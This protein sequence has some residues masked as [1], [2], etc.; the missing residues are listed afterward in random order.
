MN[1]ERLV[2]L[3]TDFQEGSPYIAQ[4]K[5]VLYSYAQNVKIVDGT[6]SIPPQN[7]E[8]AAYT[9]AQIVPFFPPETIHIVVVDPG[10][11]SSRRLVA[12]PYGEQFILCP[13]NGILTLLSE[14]MAIQKSYEIQNRTYFLRE[15]SATF[16]GRDIL[17]P[18]AAWLA[19]GGSP[20]D[21]GPAV[22]PESLVRLNIVH[23]KRSDFG[24]E[25][26]IVF[27]D[28][29]GNLITNIEQADWPIPEGKCFRLNGKL[30]VQMV[31][32][33]A[34]AQPGN[35]CAL[36]GSSGLL[37]FA[38]RNGSAAE[39][40]HLAPNSEIAVSWNF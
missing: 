27:A 32:T 3:T 18:C 34:D 11:G 2:V 10:V 8:A 7:I 19:N 25:A 1:F 17:A 39:R 21:L 38:V 30:S 35:L 28:A 23:S 13:D 37:E 15:V 6:H 26:R 40:T 31:R 36:F 16:H 5:G 33:Y 20:A 24:L 14:K 9:L 4:M 22:P 29:F 12:V